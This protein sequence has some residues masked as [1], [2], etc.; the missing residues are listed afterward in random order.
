MATVAARSDGSRA[1]R[2]A[3]YGLDAICLAALKISGG[4]DAA[5]FARR[6]YERVADKDLAAA[7]AEQ[8]NAASSTC[9]GFAPA[10]CPPSPRSRLQSRPRPPRLRAHSIVQIVNDDCIPGRFD[11]QQF[12]RR[13][14]GVHLLAHPVMA[15][16]RDLDGVC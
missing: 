14:I 5:Q 2:P 1:Q 11:R 15:A 4:E 7:P 3:A 8:R 13:E 10:A 9:W 16:R 6:L 12:N